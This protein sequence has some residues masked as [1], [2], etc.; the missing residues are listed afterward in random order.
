MPETY[1]VKAFASCRELA[2]NAAGA[3]APVGELSVYSQTF[4]RDR[5]LFSTGLKNT[6][7][8][9]NPL[10]ADTTLECDVTVYSSRDDANEKVPTN[11]HVATL[12]KMVSLWIYGTG[13]N[14]TFTDEAE[15]ARQLFLNDNTNPDVTNL[16]MGPMVE[17]DSKWY[18]KQMVFN[19]SGE[20]LI[21][22]LTAINDETAEDDLESLALVEDTLVRLWFADDL[23]RAEFDE[24]EINHVAPIAVL[25]GFFQS[26]PNVQALV[27][28]QTFPMMIKK[29][30]QLAD[31]DPY[32]VLISNTF[33]FHDPV[34]PAVTIATNWSAVIYGDA[35]RNPDL[36][37]LTLIDWILA[38]SSHTREEW[39]I[40]FPDIF[41]V[42]EFVLI[43][44]WN[45]YS[46]PN[47][48]LQ[49]GVYS[50]IMDLQDAMIVANKMAVG[51][52]YTVKQIVDSLVYVG[53]PYKSLA[54]VSVSGPQ[55]RP[56][57]Q[58]LRE[59]WPDYMAVPTS[60]LD[61]AR[62]QPATQEF[63]EMLTILLN[64]AE[65]MT[66]L[67][68]IPQ[69][70]SRIKRFDADDN[71]VHYIAGTINNVSYLVLAKFSLLDTY[72][73]QEPEFNP[74][75]M[76]LSLLPAD[77]LMLQTEI[78]SKELSVDFEVV[79]GV[80]P[81]TF[82]VAPSVNFVDH[83][84]GPSTGQLEIEFAEFGQF[85]IT[86]TVED[87]LDNAY[88]ASYAVNVRP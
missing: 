62:M 68:V 52:D 57:A 53:T 60:N 49:E 33:N 72:P 25:D 61:F 24:Y 27:N 76:P 69:G 36:I 44:M 81:Y 64:I 48:T 14:G 9:D 20:S 42:T 75:N 59:V 17:S 18:P 4:T 19:I 21:A 51:E 32:T 87:S 41:K 63:V 77:D 12:L 13:G 22:Y 8:I 65:E 3:I 6:L 84:M 43:P 15:D 28:Q 54:M 67:S 2:D 78:G 38:N 40:R 74:D 23:F 31:G 7:D 26:T 11:P 37:K 66:T 1:S 56:G 10:L 71:P 50:P 79:G 34:N 16:V 58:K 83:A 70:Y 86:V 85:V 47:M 46:V 5:E 80:A 30:D 45:K 73:A 88:I 29:V 82:S 39:E 35:G 55:N